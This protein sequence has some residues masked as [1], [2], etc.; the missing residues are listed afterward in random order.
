MSRIPPLLAVLAAT[1]ASATFADSAAAVDSQPCGAAVFKSWS[2][3]KVQP[4]PL[5]APL[6]PN[7]WVPVYREPVA[8][9]PGATAPTPDGWL[10]GT[11]DQ[12]FVCDARVPDASYTHPNG[13][14]NDWWAYTQAD[15][16]DLWGWV[17]EVFFAGGANDEPDAGLRRCPS[18]P[19]APGGGDPPSPGEPAPGGA[20]QSCASEPTVTSAASLEAQVSAGRRAA[21]ELKVGYGR[22]TEVVGILRDPSGNAVAN[23]ALCLVARPDGQ[24]GPFLELARTTTD[25]DGHYRVTVAGGPSREI[26]V[27]YRAGSASVVK[28]TVIKVVP[29]ITA[30]PSRA[31]LRNGQTL[32]ITGHLSG[33]PFPKRGVLVSLQAMRN[34]RWVGFHDPV[35]T[36]AQGR[37]RFTY[38]FEF[39]GVTQTYRLRTRVLAQNSYP[40]V[41]GASRAMR[42]RVRGV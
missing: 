11:T 26:L 19:A 23:A 7:G 4:C 28:R 25:A 15:G 32:R 18:S 29:R 20:D 12:Y 34:G 38:R 33:G 9:A 5:A 21:R 6:P 13:W 8:V 2:A 41:T 27:V 1:V 39:T 24:D 37:Y 16:S 10:H 40:Y 17:P 22:K 35:R 42:V 3:E 36:D 31:S 14:R 30:R